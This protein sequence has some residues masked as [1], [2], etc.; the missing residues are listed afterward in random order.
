MNFT[1]QLGL[2]QKTQQQCQ[3][4]ISPSHT[5]ISL[6]HTHIALSHTHISLS[7]THISLSHTHLSSIFLCTHFSLFLTMYLFSAKAKARHPSDQSL[8]VDEPWRKSPNVYRRSWKEVPRLAVSVAMEVVVVEH[9]KWVRLFIQV[10]SRS[11]A[12]GE[13]GITHGSMGSTARY[14]PSL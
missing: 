11:I 3:E 7:H 13:G 14:L 8:R 2:R 4:T 10:Q 5:H 1:N 6:S 9:R 12:N